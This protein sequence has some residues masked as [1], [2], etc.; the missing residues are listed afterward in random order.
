MSRLLTPTDVYQ[1]ANAWQEE[2]I[3][4]KA[5]IQA[6]DTSSLTSV[7]EAIMASGFE[8]TLNSLYMLMG[9]LW[10]AARKYNGKA[11]IVQARNTGVYTHRFAKIYNYSSRAIAS[12]YWNTNVKTN[13]A[14]GY[15]AGDNNGASTKSQYEQNPA[16][17][18]TFTFGG[19]DVLDFEAPT[20]YLDKLEMAF[21]NESEFREVIN[22][23]MVTFESDMEQYRENFNR[24]CL[25]S[26]MAQDIAMEA[27]R[28]ESVVHAVTEFNTTFGT[29]Y[30]KAE[31]KTTYSREFY[32]WLAAKLDIIMDRMAERT[33][34]FHYD[35]VKTVDGEDY[36]ILSFTPKDRLKVAAF[37]PDFTTLEK[38]VL[39]ET[40]Q[41]SELKIDTD[42]F[43]KF[44]YWQ[45]INE[46]G[47]INI[48]PA[49]LDTDSTSATYLQQ[50]PAA[51]YVE[52]EPILYLFDE[53]RVLTDEQFKRALTSPVE[54]R[55]GYYNVFHH[56]AFN[57][58]SCPVDNSCVILWD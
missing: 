36:D 19:S 17:T 7:G 15:T 37:G 21:R 9:K 26:A 27:D 6:V 8:N 42:R 23:I 4:K 41:L 51:D 50:K 10:V 53:D 44:T 24:E 56:W 5:Q 33:V 11:K 54:A 52:A 57:H 55:K 31:L 3:G 38:L 32:S 40:F 34:L 39:P 12:G 43:E 16:L 29:S 1:F 45:N 2:A 20:M 46:P 30:T 35:P 13:F 47:K 28:P 14:K 18:I 22:G 48:K 25:V 58:I 49:V